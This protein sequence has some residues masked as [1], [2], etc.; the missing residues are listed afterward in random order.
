MKV[1]ERRRRLWLAAIAALL[2]TAHA[3]SAADKPFAAWLEELRLEAAER[4]ISKATLQAALTGIEPLPRVLELDRRQPEFT[5]TFTEYLTR[6]VPGARVE[7]GRERLRESRALLD[8]I[9]KRYGVQPR[10]MVAL[11]GV[12]SDFGRVTGDFSIIQAL[13]TLAYDGRRSAFFRQELLNALRILDRG[14]IEPR[15]MRGSWAGAMGQSQFMPSSFLTF[16]VDHDGDGRRDIWTT[17]ADVL[18]S[19]ANYLAKSGWRADETWGRP[20]RLPPGFDAS[21]A[22]LDIVKPI[23]QW[24]ALGIRRT[25]AGDLPTRQLDSS[26]VLPEG[27]SGPAYL[28]YNNF[29]VLL[30]WNRSNFFAIAVGTLADRIE[31]D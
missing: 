13:A 21:L 26:I 10:F 1:A 27:L 20:V 28:V 7:K 8:D 22:N 23:G 6:V 24:Q 12:E 3:A 11:W 31:G 9:A 30:K 14:D 4:G 19:T 25:D 5:I 16:A 2:V 29:R 17:R 18:A 15:A